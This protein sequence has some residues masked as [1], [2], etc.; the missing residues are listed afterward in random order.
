MKPRRELLPLYLAAAFLAAVLAAHLNFA[1]IGWHNSVG[2]PQDFRQAQTAIAAYYIAEEGPMLATKVPVLGPTWRIPL[3]FPTYQTLVATLHRLT[4]AGLDPTGRF[5]SLACFYLCL[6]PLGYCLRRLGFSLPDTLLTLALAAASPIYLFWSRT[7]LI[8]SLALLLALAFLAAVLQYAES[9]S[10]RWLALAVSAGILAALTKFT[11]FSIAF[12]FVV[13]WLGATLVSGKMGI[14]WRGRGRVAAGIVAALL[15]PV[16]AGW[17]WTQYLQ[18]VWVQ[19]PLTR[20]MGDAIHAWNIGPWKLRVSPEFW[21]RFA[22][23]GIGKATLSFV[24]WLV[25]FAA[26]ALAPLRWRLSG[27]ALL[28]PGSRGRWC[29]PTCFSC[30]TIITTPPRFSGWS[31][32]PV[33]S[34]GWRSAGRSWGYPYG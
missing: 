8:E 10:R 18:H 14:Q 24:A 29:G 9:P 11:T 1:L 21:G 32:S 17:L 31:G 7:F 22:E 27:C 16:A 4:G 2:G 3:E 5:V 13:L 12:G 30:T 23:Y 34:S 19:S 15:V 25:G 20:T 33:A 28:A 26:F 6:L